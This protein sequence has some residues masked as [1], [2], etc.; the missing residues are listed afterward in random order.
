MQETELPTNPEETDT[1]IPEVPPHDSNVPDPEEQAGSPAIVDEERQ[2]DPEKTDTDVP[3]VS[4]WV[5]DEAEE[6]DRPMTQ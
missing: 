4:P 3:D 2:N 6:I 5:P 1:D